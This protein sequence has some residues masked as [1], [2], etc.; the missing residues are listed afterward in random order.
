MWQVAKN[1]S[2]HF[3]SWNDEFVVYNSA[4]GDTHLLGMLAAQS[5]IRLQDA[6][7][8]ISDLLDTISQLLQIQPDDE[9]KEMIEKTLIDLSC[10]GI[11]ENITH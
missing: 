10:L 8:N 1:A 3:H 5:V 9:L 11:V 2:L 6:P 4:S 7:S